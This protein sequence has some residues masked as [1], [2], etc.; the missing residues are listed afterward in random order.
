MNK[1]SKIYVAGHKN[2][3]GSAI[4]RYLKKEGYTNLILKTIEELDLTNQ[5][6]VNFFFE[7]EKPEYVFLAASKAGGILAKSTQPATF[8]YINSM[9]Q[10]NIIQSSNFHKVKKLL[11]LGSSCAYPELTEQPIKEEALLTGALEPSNEAYALAKING[12]KMCQYYREELGNDF[13]SVIPTNIYGIN[14]DFDLKRAHVVSAL[15]RKF[16]E[17]KQSGSNEVVVWGTGAPLREFHFVDDLAEGLIWLMKTYSEKSH[18]N[19]GT[20]EEISISDLA[21]KIAKLVGYEGKIV[22]DTSKP[23]GTPRKVM[24]CSKIKA[25]G[26]KSNVNLDE[27]LEKTYAWFKEELVGQ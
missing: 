7:V 1:T 17:A 18:I 2:M 16:H 5:R 24:D 6:D 20:G 15:I 11:F 19:I 4:V 21:N 8:S 14:D 22:Q 25:M 26:W 3:V 10:N 13:I 12:I 9:M 23:D 27:G